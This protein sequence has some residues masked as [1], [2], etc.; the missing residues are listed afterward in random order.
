MDDAIIHLT[1]K[2]MTEALSFWVQAEFKN[3]KKV[4]D[5]VWDLQTNRF[6][7]YLAGPPPVETK[8]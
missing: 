8:K 7:V 5:V 4:A 2:D 1:K 6:K 3:P